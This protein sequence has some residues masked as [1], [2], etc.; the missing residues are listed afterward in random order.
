MTDAAYSEHLKRQILEAYGFGD[1]M[2]P[3]DREVWD[4]YSR[5][6]DAVDAV[7]KASSANVM[8]VVEAAPAWMT[9][10]MRARGE[11]PEGLR[12]EWSTA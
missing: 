7:N 3:G 2:T 8:A 9:E 12:F 5:L 6:M 10:Y 4:A 1:D 11:L